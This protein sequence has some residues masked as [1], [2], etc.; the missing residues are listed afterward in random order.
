MKNE[1][2]QLYRKDKKLALK[3]AKVLGYKIKVVALDEKKAKNKLYSLIE[4][5]DRIMGKIEKI[6]KQYDLNKF[7]TGP[8]EKPTEYDLFK[9]INKS[10]N[11]KEFCNQFNFPEKFYKKI[12]KYNQDFRRYQ[13]AA[14][15]LLD[16]ISLP[17]K[18]DEKIFEKLLGY[19]LINK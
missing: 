14:L 17:K 8:F 6:I 11:M 9:A 10:Q 5:T 7:K 16:V 4:K 2:K 15:A 19:D 12:K 13:Q 3:V 18:E 1:I